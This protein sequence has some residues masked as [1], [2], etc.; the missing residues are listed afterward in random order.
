MNLGNANK[1]QAIGA[2]L[3]NMEAQKP[4]FINAVKQKMRADA[5]AAPKGLFGLGDWADDIMGAF[6][7]DQT[8]EQ[9]AA[10]PPPD[11]DVSWWEDA[12]TGV[13]DAAGKI[14]PAY[15]AYEKEKDWN[16]I[17]LERAKA[18][19]APLATAGYGA[20]PTTI[21]VTMP[22]GSAARAAGIEPETMN[23]ILVGGGILGALWLFTK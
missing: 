19:Q 8:G 7:S 15:F 18:G 2:V 5:G 14:I 23:M 21:Q 11:S 6:T 1:R 9:P 4:G 12:I 17:Q 20:P 13:T 16:A 10:Q 3:L 22:P